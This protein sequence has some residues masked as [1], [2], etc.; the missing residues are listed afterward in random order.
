MTWYDTWHQFL[1][2]SINRRT[3]VPGRGSWGR[4]RVS[5]FAWSH[6]WSASFYSFH[7][8]LDLGIFTADIIW[9]IDF[10][11]RTIRVF[12]GRRRIWWIIRRES[13]VNRW[14]VAF[15]SLALHIQRVIFRLLARIVTIF[16]HISENGSLQETLIIADTCVASKTLAST[17]LIWL[18]YSFKRRRRT[19]L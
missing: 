17:F 10:G 8:H 6:I 4:I 13:V 2:F 19:V 18:L 7:I 5:I 3:R 12:I 16:L 1:P 11:S 9:A 14:S 15:P